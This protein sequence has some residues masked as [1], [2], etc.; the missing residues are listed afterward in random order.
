[1]LSEFGDLVDLSL[2][3]NQQRPYGSTGPD[4]P[5]AAPGEVA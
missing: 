2:G 3:Q 4:P 5:L 1:M